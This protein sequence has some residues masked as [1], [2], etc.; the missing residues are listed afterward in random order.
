[1]VYVA[2]TSESLRSGFAHGHFLVWR[3]VVRNGNRTPGVYRKFHGGDLRSDPEQN[4]PCTSP[5]KSGNVPRIGAHHPAIDRKGSG[6]AVPERRGYP[7]GPH[8]P[9]ARFGLPSL[10]CLCRSAIRTRSIGKHKR[11]CCSRHLSFTTRCSSK[12]ESRVA[13]RADC[14][15]CCW[16]GLRGLS[17]LAGAKNCPDRTRENHQDQPV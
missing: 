6:L 8:T 7:R 4:A 16:R 12:K 15:A 1:R 11:C 9:Q 2:R 5:G 17:L 3:G 10:G 14:I 13:A